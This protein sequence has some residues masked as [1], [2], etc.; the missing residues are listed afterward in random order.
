MIVDECV[1]LWLE[2]M[3][4]YIDKIDEFVVGI[5]IVDFVENDELVDVIVFCLM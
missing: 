3:K 2:V 4:L 5:F 1:G